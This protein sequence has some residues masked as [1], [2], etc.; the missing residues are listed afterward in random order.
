MLLSRS[1]LL[2]LHSE[3]TDYDACDLKQ[4][5]NIILINLK[6]KLQ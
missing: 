4:I 1:F 2:T 5:M 3:Q 6:I